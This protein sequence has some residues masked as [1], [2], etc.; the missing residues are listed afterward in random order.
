M[1][2]QLESEISQSL[3]TMSLRNI[4]NSPAK[5]TRGKELT[6]ARRRTIY[7]LRVHAGWTIRR[8]AQNLN[9]PRST[10]HRLSVEGQH[11]KFKAKQ[12]TGRPQIVTP[13]IRN[14][15]VSIA[16]A[17]AHNRRL[18]F[19][20]LASL[21][22]L[23][24]STE[25]VRRALREEGFNRR[26]ARQKPFLTAT[27]KANRYNWALEHASWGIEE[28]RRVIWTDEASFNVG[29]AHGRIWVTR[30]PGE[31]FNEDC[32]VP[33]FKK[34]SLLMVWGAISGAG[35]RLKLVFWDK[36]KWG[37]ITG[38]SYRDHIL[39][40][41]LLPLYRCEQRFW[42]SS[43]IMEDNAPVHNCSINK[44]VRIT[45]SLP[46]LPWPSGSPDLNPIEDVWH[47]MKEAISSLPTRPTTITTME[48]AIWAIWAQIGTSEI[49][50]M[51]DSMPLRVQAVLA[52]H[53]GHTSF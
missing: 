43:P 35:G 37:T 44:E 15:L 39:L 21:I 42:G 8:I 38:K 11:G 29:G 17:S 50:A 23:R 24:L 6:E 9:I 10:T 13:I 33:K 20:S 14:K 22:G 53:G 18:P 2:D 31:E 7:A 19:S 4:L 25:V 51:V 32:L 40:P 47:R 30:R 46:R 34:L 36:K 1:E 45:H 27:Q 16:T 26:V 3:E 41:N 5:Q 52:V 28:W 49:Q 48:N 12:R